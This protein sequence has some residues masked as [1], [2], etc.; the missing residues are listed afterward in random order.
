MKF[1]AG[2]VDRTVPIGL[3]RN[4]LLPFL[5]YFLGASSGSLPASPDGIFTHAALQE[6]CFPAK[7]RVTDAI[8][9]GNF[10]LYCPNQHSDEAWGHPLKT[11]TGNLEAQE[12]PL[13]VEN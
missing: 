6:A 10:C 13:H 7:F 2:C 12:S 11:V 3:G 9:L 5:P 8:T 1:P 4:L